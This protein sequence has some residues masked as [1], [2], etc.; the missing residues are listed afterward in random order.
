LSKKIW[1]QDP[2]LM[3]TS[4]ATSVCKHNSSG[5]ASL[6]ALEHT[7]DR[8][9]TYRRNTEARSRN[10][11]R[12]GRAISIT[13]SEY[14]SAALFIQHS[15]CVR[16]IAVTSAACLTPPYFFHIISQTAR[17]SGGGGG[18]GGGRN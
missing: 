12:R 4:S 17:L 5:H 16:C 18:G 2:M 9:Y 3:P 8:K 11:C 13:Y 6:Y 1:W 15:N 10:Q 7:P 14:M